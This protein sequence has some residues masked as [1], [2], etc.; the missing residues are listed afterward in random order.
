MPGGVIQGVAALEA[1]DA[2]EGQ[3]KRG[4]EAV[5]RI[6]QQI[7]DDTASQRELGTEATNFLRGL[8]FQTGPDAG[9]FGGAVTEDVANPEF[10][11]LTE[12]L[13]NTSP[14]AGSVRNP[15]ADRESDQKF[16]PGANPEFNRLQQ[17]LAETPETISREVPGGS[18]GSDFNFGDFAKRFDP[19]F[20][21]RQSEGIRALDNSA[22][23]R[24]VLN[25]GAQQRA[26]IQFGE[27]IANQSSGNFLNRLTQLAGFGTNATLQGNQFQ[28]TNALTQAGLFQDAGAARASGIIG[29]GQ[30]FGQAA[31]NL[32]QFALFA[33]GCVVA[34]EV[35]GKD[36]PQWVRFRR[37]LV[38]RAPAK[39]Q[40]FYIA[41]GKAIAK[42]ISTRPQAKAMLREVMEV[43]CNG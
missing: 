28:A 42:W 8:F 6:F 30:G 9:L 39:L 14:T 4:R 7:R 16:L 11:R 41:H 22:A 2:Q 38:H 26:A 40:A 23:A 17:L 3:I 27:N 15:A 29:A 35:F 24:G 43:H 33:G 5:E 36:N 10:L 37:F 34:R 1:A 31:N 21:F 20:D 25:S 13:A 18:A 32:A 19:T 12:L